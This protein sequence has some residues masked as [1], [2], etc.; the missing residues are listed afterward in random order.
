[1]RFYGRWGEKQFG[2]KPILSQVDLD[3]RVFYEARR[4]AARLRLQK[5]REVSART[6]RR[7]PRSAA[8]VRG[9]D[10]LKVFGVDGNAIGARLVECATQVALAKASQP[11]PD[12]GPVRLRPELARAFSELGGQPEPD[13]RADFFW[14]DDYESD[15]ERIEAWLAEDERRREAANAGA[16]LAMEAEQRRERRKEEIR[17]KDRKERSRSRRDG[18]RGP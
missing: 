2:F 8:R 10:G 17:W 12:R 11:Q 5:M 4:M 6:G 7:V 13:E 3:E 15:A 18:E 9:R 14:P 1:L 16:I